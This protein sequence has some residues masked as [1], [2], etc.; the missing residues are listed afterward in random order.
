MEALLKLN[1]ILW[2]HMVFGELYSDE[3]VKYKCVEV[4]TLAG[5]RLAVRFDDTSGTASVNGIPIS[6]TVFDV[7]GEFYVFHAIEGLLV[8]SEFVSC[9]DDDLDFSPI[10]A[11]GKYN[12]ILD[13]VG[14]KPLLAQDISMNRPV[15]KL[16]NLFYDSVGCCGV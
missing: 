3:V 15:S 13:W 16:T 7:R 10:V 11:A 14:K 6:S 4:D 12:T 9:F 2:G 5:T 8:D 1:D